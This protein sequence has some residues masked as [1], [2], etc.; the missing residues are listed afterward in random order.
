MNL[1]ATLVAVAVAALPTVLSAGPVAEA[2]A[3][4]RTAYGHYR[5]ALFQSNAGKADATAAAIAA[6]ASAWGSLS[7]DWNDKPPPQYADD[8]AL[9][10]TLS[11]V[12]ALVAAASEEVAAGELAAAHETLEG[13]RDAIGA[14]H[15]RNHMIGFSDRMNAYHAVMEEVLAEGVPADGSLGALRE[16][17]AVLAY[18]AADIAAHPAPEAADPAYAPMIDALVSSVASLQAATR[19]GDVDAAKAAVSAL[20]M[21]YAKLFATFG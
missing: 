20:K 10:A 15:A 16:H 14:L 3:D 18:L 21:P 6:L 19:A 2:E 11:Q 5:T 7:M 12:A 1:Q 4:L 9:A 17:A 13:V 8:P